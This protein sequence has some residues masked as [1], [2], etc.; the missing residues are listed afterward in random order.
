MDAKMSLSP[1]EYSHSYSYGGVPVEGITPV[2]DKSWSTSS[3]VALNIGTVGMVR[4]VFTV[5]PSTAE[6]A[7]SRFESVTT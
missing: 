1:V 2:T 6:V 7:M 4:A 5:T 3:A